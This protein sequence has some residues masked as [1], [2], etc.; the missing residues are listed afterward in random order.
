MA[1]NNIKTTETLEFSLDS[2]V[3]QRDGASALMSPFRG[4]LAPSFGASDDRTAGK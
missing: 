3:R 2:A 4:G 1:E